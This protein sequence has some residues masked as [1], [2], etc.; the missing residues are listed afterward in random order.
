MSQKEYRK[1]LADRRPAPGINPTFEPIVGQ[2][3][4]AAAPTAPQE[5]VEFEDT[6]EPGPAPEPG[7]SWEDE[8]RRMVEEQEFTARQNAAAQEEM[9]AAVP[10]DPVAAAQAVE[11]RANAAL[12]REVA[13]TDEQP[14]DGG[15]LSGLAAEGVQETVATDGFPSTEAGEPEARP[16]SPME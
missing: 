2:T 14:D 4:A 15:D 3:P 8:Q 1:R 5:P 10:Q 12:G 7:V 11:D 9:Q 13:S 6:G 16:R